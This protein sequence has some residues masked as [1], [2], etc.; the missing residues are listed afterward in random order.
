MNVGAPQTLSLCADFGIGDIGQ[1]R[2]KVWIVTT[3]NVDGNESC[4]TLYY[5]SSPDRDAE[6]KLEIVHKHWAI[7]NK[8]HRVL[9]AESNEDQ[10]GVRKYQKLENP[11][12][13]RQI[14]LNLF[15]Q[16]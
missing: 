16:E 11:P 2:K 12:A 8:L 3:R 14:T 15:C 9:D 10:G 4:G 5:I 6:Q 7:E 13:G 1:G